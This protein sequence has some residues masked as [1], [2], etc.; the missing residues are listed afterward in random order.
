VAYNQLEAQLREI[1]SHRRK[2]DRSRHAL[3]VQFADIH[4]RM[5]LTDPQTLPALLLQD[6]ADAAHARTLAATIQAGHTNGMAR[7]LSPSSLRQSPTKPDVALQLTQQQLLDLSQRMIENLRAEVGNLALGTEHAALR[8]ELVTLSLSA[9]AMRT[10]M[11]T[12]AEHIH[13]ITQEK[14]DRFNQT[15]ASHTHLN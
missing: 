1:Q 15:A 5:E 7:P 12:Y 13:I 4:G 11:N 8:K 14:L 3:L 10:K 9:L 6:S 2:H